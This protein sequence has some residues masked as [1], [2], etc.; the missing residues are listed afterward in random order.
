MR[1]VRNALGRLFNPNISRISL[2]TTLSPVPGTS[3]ASLFK[4]MPALR[5]MSEKK[6]EPKMDYAILASK[7]YRL[8]VTQQHIERAARVAEHHSTLLGKEEKSSYY[9]DALLY[10]DSLTQQA[11]KEK[12]NV[13][14][15]LPYLDTHINGSHFPL[16]PRQIPKEWKDLHDKGVSEE[17]LDQMARELKETV[18]LMVTPTD[19]HRAVKDSLNLLSPEQLALRLA[20][21]NSRLLSERKSIE[22]AT[23]NNRVVAS[24]R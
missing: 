9:N 18:Q 6:E 7:L 22:P 2:V 3:Y 23:E 20:Y 17:Q 13:N 21:T 11:K 16:T 5:F 12:L 8:G 24:R 19:Y 10:L 14:S 15:L 4:K 1:S